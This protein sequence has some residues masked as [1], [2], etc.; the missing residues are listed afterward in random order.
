M[1]PH[2]FEKNKKK[3]PY[4]DSWGERDLNPC[5]H[6]QQIYSLSPLTTRPS[7]RLKHSRLKELNPQPA[8]YKS[9][10]LPIELNR[11][12]TFKRWLVY[13]S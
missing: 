11:Q 8:D 1:Q 5:R 7:P 12:T 3:E 2:K 4:K 13:T 6:S 9:A 10:A